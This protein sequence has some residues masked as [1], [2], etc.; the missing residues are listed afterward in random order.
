MDNDKRTWELII[1][2]SGGVSISN[3]EP[4]KTPPPTNMVEAAEQMDITAF[5]HFGHEQ[6]KELSVYGN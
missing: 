3:Q 2:L 6:R 4:I 1:A 5:L